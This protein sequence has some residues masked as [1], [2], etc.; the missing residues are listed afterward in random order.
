MD[1]R[2]TIRKEVLENLKEGEKDGSIQ[3]ME[4]RM[5]RNVFSFRDKDAKEVMSHRKNIVALSC[6]DTL[7]EA[8]DFASRA[9]YSRFP[10]YEEE[11]DNI[12]G[13]IHIRDIMKLYLNTEMRNKKF[14]EIPDALMPVSFIPE[15]RKIGRLFMQMKAKQTHLCVVIDEYGQTAGLVAMEDIIEEIM[16]NIRDEY[17]EEEEMIR[18][19]EDGSYEVN[20]LCGLTELSDV[21]GII[22]QDEDEDNEYETLN[23]FLIVK[24]ERI[25][26][27]DELCT[28][29]YEGYLFE[30]KEV[31]NNIIQKVKITK[32]EL[33]TGSKE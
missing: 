30:I 13:I 10:V 14:R 4:Y 24:L 22:F 1:Q 11:I 15:T 18:K 20:G 3:E 2:D 29:S 7:E 5:I 33:V 21:L 6:D 23:G 19:N 32:T 28:V 12:L 8:A 31:D 9:K 27:E 16:G 17:D 26:A 25:P